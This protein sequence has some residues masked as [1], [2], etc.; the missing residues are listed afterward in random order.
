[1]LHSSRAMLTQHGQQGK[2]CATSHMSTT[3]HVS[4]ATNRATLCPAVLPPSHEP[5][6]LAAVCAGP[7]AL[8]RSCHASARLNVPWCTSRHGRMWRCALL[9]VMSWCGSGGG[10]SWA[11]NWRQSEP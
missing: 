2:P 4:R 3:T 5:S 10:V 8:D 1:M 11:W 9:V 6:V 7:A